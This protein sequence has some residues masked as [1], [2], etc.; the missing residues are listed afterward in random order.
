LAGLLDR[1][2]VFLASAVE[3][4]KKALDLAR[5]KYKVGQTELLNVLHIQAGWVGARVG[6]LD[7][8]NQQLA[9]RINLHLALGG[10]F[11]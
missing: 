8:K 5:V 10:G 1:R 11:E 3:S 9:E 4:N 2:E 6:H 7:V